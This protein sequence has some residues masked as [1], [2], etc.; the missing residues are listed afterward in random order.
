MLSLATGRYRANNLIA[1]GLMTGAGAKPTGWFE[2]PGGTGTAPTYQIIS[3]STGFL[4]AGSFAEMDFN[5]VS[6]GARTFACAVGSGW[7]VGDTLAVT[8]KMQVSDVAGNWH[9]SALGGASAGLSARLTNQSGV[10]MNAILGVQNT[11]GLPRGAGLFNIGAIATRIVV[12]TGTTSIALWFTATLPT[13]GNAKIRIGEVGV[14]NL[15][16]LGIA[17]GFN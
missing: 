17:S 10:G 15:T 4:S 6:G 3:D 1:N 9:D 14:F 13:G 2:Q 8:A 16:K 7:S 12:P 11:A 5:A